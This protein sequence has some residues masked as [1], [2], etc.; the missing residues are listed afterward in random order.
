MFKFP[1]QSS[2][3]VLQKLIRKQFHQDLVGKL[4]PKRLSSCWFSVKALPGKIL[5]LV[6]L[7]TQ[8]SSWSITRK[9]R[10]SVAR[11]RRECWWGGSKCSSTSS[12]GK[13]STRFEIS[14]WR[15]MNIV[16]IVGFIHPV[17]NAIKLLQACIYKS[18]NTGLILISLVATSIVKFIL[19]MLDRWSIRYLKVKTSINVWN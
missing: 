3:P 17:A 10:P 19:L 11:S 4:C 6:F 13:R 18:V 2:W 7:L 5:T 1:A 15:E 14:S 12:R 9:S 8:G 16:V